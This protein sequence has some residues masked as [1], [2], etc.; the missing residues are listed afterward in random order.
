M[1]KDY[2]DCTPLNNLNF[3]LIKDWYC[4]SVWPVFFYLSFF[5]VFKFL[6]RLH[7]QQS[8]SY[9]FHNLLLSWC[10]SLDN[11]PS[12]ISHHPLN[13]QKHPLVHIAIASLLQCLILMLSVSPPPTFY[14]TGKV[15]FRGNLPPTKVDVSSNNQLLELS[16]IC[17]LSLVPSYN[18]NASQR[19]GG[20]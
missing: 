14:L 19:I 4:Q 13:Q 6:D 18:L 2:P 5:F 10:N 3:S 9:L 11:Q 7:Y 17:H 15:N 12:A 8:K 16:E 20:V 1:I